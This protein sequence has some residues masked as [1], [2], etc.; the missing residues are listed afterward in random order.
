MTNQEIFDKGMQGMLKQEAFAFEWDDDS[1]D[2]FYYDSLGNKCFV[3]HLASSD[4]QSKEWEIL[5]L[6]AYQI[7]DDMG[8]DGRFLYSAQVHHDAIA[9]NCKGVWDRKAFIDGMRQFAI[10]NELEF[11][12]K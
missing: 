12:Y 11:N 3:G 7:A 1:S 6:T 9:D 4:E 5:K 2:C 10:D 8:I